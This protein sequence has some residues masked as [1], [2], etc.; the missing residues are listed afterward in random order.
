MDKL[1]MITL[2]LDR[3]FDAWQPGD[4]DSLADTVAQSAGVSKEQVKILDCQRGS[5]IASTVI[6]APDWSAVSA[7]LEASLKDQSGPFKDLG[8]VG[9]GA[10]RVRLE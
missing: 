1:R 3:D 10:K 2:S 9:R 8:V 4:A 5:V 7:K 6:M